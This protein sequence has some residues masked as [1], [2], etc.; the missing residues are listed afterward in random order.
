MRLRTAIPVAAAIVGLAALTSGAAA[1]TSA[2]RAAQATHARFACYPAQFS[3]FGAQ[4][5]TIVDQFSRLAS[6]SFTVPET[7]CAPAPGLSTGYLTCYTINAVKSAA[8]PGPVRASDEFAKSIS[9]APAKLLTLCLPSARVDGGG[10]SVTSKGLDRFTCYAAKASV[11]THEG[12]PV[13]DDFGNSNDS[14]GA[15]LRFCAPVAWKGSSVADSTRFLSC[16]TDQSATKGKIVIL[17][18]EFG[19]LKAALG[20]R[21]WLCATATL[22]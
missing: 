5:R 12:V 20:P 21:A 6:V 18:N 8:T 11:V 10:S 19:Y 7:V 14:I 9:V 2:P 22:S 13:I 16:Y 15:P 1:S 3:P 4:T 17:R